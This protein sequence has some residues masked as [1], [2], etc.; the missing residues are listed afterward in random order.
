MNTKST[1]Q[2]PIPATYDFL[3]EQ[4]KEYRSPK[5]KISRLA[6][7]GSLIRLRKGFYLPAT[8]E[9]Q[10]EL[11][12]NLLHGPSYISLET[13]LSF[14]GMIP[15]RVYA[16]RSVT[17]KRSK[18]Y[19]TP[20][21]RFEYFTAKEGYFSVGVR[22]AIHGSASILIASPGTTERKNYGC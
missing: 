12:A 8:A 11:A 5:D 18:L 3:K 19:K 22:S 13:A 10:A 7:E 14:Y 4:Y 9:R 20:I 17:T 21:G 1:I 16:I 2:M 6:A 15:E